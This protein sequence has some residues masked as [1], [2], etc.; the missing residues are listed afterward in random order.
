[1]TLNQ[2]LTTFEQH[3]RVADPKRG[4]IIAE[5]RGHLAEKQNLG[6]PRRLAHEYNQVHLGLVGSSPAIFLLPWVLALPFIL[7][8]NAY[9]DFGAWGSLTSNVATTFANIAYLLVPLWIGHSAARMK[10]ARMTIW[11]F[12][13][14]TALTT[15]TWFFLIP[16]LAPEPF[17]AA[18][19]SWSLPLL[20]LSCG[21][22]IFLGWVGY[23]LT[24]TMTWRSR[25]PI[26]RLMHYA[27]LATLWLTVWLVMSLTWMSS[28][29]LLF[30]IPGFANS[31]IMTFF[32]G[33]PGSVIIAGLLLGPFAISNI[34]MVLRR[35]QT[36]IP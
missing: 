36:H 6:D 33:F 3:L 29:G 23:W 15:V 20:A 17:R 14:S 13:A 18:T 28:F 7:F 10:A 8:A 22:S 26:G 24:R 30:F 35:T 19:N 34:R 31:R 12:S 9:Y 21:I 11:R 5:I 1:M 32:A 2:Y 27:E 4:E 16:I 25:Q